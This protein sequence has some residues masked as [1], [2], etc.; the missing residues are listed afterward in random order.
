LSPEEI[1]YQALANDSAIA[2]IVGNRISSRHVILGQELPCITFQMIGGHMHYTQ[3]G[4]DAMQSPVVQIDCWARISSYDVLTA[5][6]IAVIDC[7][8]GADSPGVGRYFLITDDGTDF[9]EEKGTI[10][11]KKIDAIVWHNRNA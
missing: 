4:L 3:D 10:G 1:V 9:V 5:L 8:N 7:L 11:R 6:R 2:L